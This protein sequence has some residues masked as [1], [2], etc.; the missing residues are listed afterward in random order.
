MF[1]AMGVPVIASRQES[2]HF[3]EEYDCGV[4][5]DNYD[6]FLAAIRHIGQHLDRMRQNCYRCFGEYIMPPDRYPRLRQAIASIQ[7]T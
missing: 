4:L 6:E 7:A 1:I 2:F 3:I 5:V